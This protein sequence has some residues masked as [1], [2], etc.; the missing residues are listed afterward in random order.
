MGSGLVSIGG[1]CHRPRPERLGRYSISRVSQ[2]RTKAAVRGTK[3]KSTSGRRPPVKV[4][5]G[6]ELP[7]LPIAIG[8]ILVVA[9]IILIIYGVVQAQGKPAVVVP[10][11]NGIPC[12]ALEHTQVHNHAALQIFY[13]GNP[14]SIPSDIGRLSTCFYWLHMHVES[15][16]VIHMESPKGR[17][18]TLGDFFKVW[19]VS[20]GTP[21]PLDATHVSSFILTPDQKLV[22][23]VDLGNGTGP[24]LYSGDP[25]AIV[26]K[27]H[28]V[29]TLE[30]SP[31]T[32]N[33]PPKFTFQSGL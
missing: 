11:A 32:V 22:V 28:E 4:K 12:D 13:Q 18:F 9:A 10:A 30:I 1:G 14:V 2:T 6:T 25:A 23:Y 7:L 21:E 5:K 16:G 31:P 26:L 27:A 15:P 33:P 3:V 17:T 8:G 24:Q 20:K 19:Q 29:I